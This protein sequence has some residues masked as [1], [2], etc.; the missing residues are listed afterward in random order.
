M[1]LEGIFSPAALVCWRLTT[2][3]PAGQA[4]EQPL[5]IDPESG[6]AIAAFLGCREMAL[7]LF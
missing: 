3:G 7:H 1:A 4:A 6:A 2:R 5:Y